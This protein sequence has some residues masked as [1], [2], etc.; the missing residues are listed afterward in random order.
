MKKHFDIFEELQNLEMIEVNTNE[1]SVM[2][3]T[4]ELKPIARWH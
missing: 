1:L 2:N 4:V 3:L